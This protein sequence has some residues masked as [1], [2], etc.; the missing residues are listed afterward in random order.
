MALSTTL[1]NRDLCEVVNRNL[2]VRSG[3]DFIIIIIYLLRHWG[4]TDY[5]VECTSV[6]YVH[7]ASTVHHG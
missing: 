6:V 7:S 2:L 4:I 3:D 5:D 1:Q